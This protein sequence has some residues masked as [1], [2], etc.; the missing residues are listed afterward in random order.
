MGISVVNLTKRFGEFTAVDRVNFDVKEGE[1][2]AL[3][4]PSG[5]GKST[6]LRMIC[7]LETPDD[8]EIYLTG[9]NATSLSIQ[10][11]GVGF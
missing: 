5:S 11:P 10:K 4:G 7:G 1:L 2:V 9:E 6:I 3:L 8:G